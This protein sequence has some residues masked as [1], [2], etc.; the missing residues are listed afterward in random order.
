MGEGGLGTLWSA[1][2]SQT[3]QMVVLAE[4]GDDTAL[5]VRDAILAGMAILLRIP[6]NIYMWCLLELDMLCD[7]VL[8]NI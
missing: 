2:D 7:C 8:I 4:E 3:G 5:A 1:Q 6:I